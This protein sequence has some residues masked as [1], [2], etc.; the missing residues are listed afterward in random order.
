MAELQAGVRA[1]EAPDGGA[2]ALAV[3][4][5]LA[6]VQRRLQRQAVAE[7]HRL[8]DVLRAQAREVVEVQEVGRRE[9][10]KREQR[11]QTVRGLV[12][13][14]LSL[15]LRGLA[16]SRER[17][18]LVVQKREAT[19]DGGRGDEGVVERQRER[20][21]GGVRP[22]AAHERAEVRRAGQHQP[23]QRVL[24]AERRHAHVA[25]L[26]G[27]P[28]QRL[29]VRGEAGR[30]AGRMVGN[31]RGEIW[32]GRTH[33]GGGRRP[34]GGGHAR[35]RRVAP[36]AAVAVHHRVG[37]RRERVCLSRSRILWLGSA[38]RVVHFGIEGRG[39]V[40]IERFCL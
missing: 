14:S 4:A 11:V 30:R 1:D 26:P 33:F 36:D 8:G 31:R 16:A 38:R 22:R 18:R 2:R 32:R 29:D 3:L 40:A 28:S 13:V 19:L 27:L 35:E 20:R 21:R 15:L 17:G 34:G 25:E 5:V 23:V 9:H 7:R 12:A 39:G 6:R 37:S 24:L 10:A